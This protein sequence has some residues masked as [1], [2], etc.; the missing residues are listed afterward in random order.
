MQIYQIF[1]NPP[2]FFNNKKQI[3]THSA[4]FFHT[5]K[6]SNQKPT[7]PPLQPAGGLVV[8]STLLWHG[9]IIE[10][11][12]Q[13]QP[14]AQ[15]ATSI[16][17]SLKSLILIKYMALMIYPTDF[18]TASKRWSKHP[19]SPHACLFLSILKKRRIFATR[20]KTMTHPRKDALP[21]TK[22]R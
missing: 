1:P 12:L 18:S 9:A 22:Y 15:K 10:M 16:D 20:K 8:V 14:M 3:I 19:V 4:I 7:S 11:N 5:S 6:A 2:N 13:S 17:C 21:A